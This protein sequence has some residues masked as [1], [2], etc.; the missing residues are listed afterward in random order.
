MY[1]INKGHN[2]P[3]IRRCKTL[4]GYSTFIA[5][6]REYEKKVKAREEAMK[7]A[8]SDCIKNNILKDFFEAH[9]SEVINM[10][11][12]EWNWD[13]ALAVR[14]EEGIEKG[15]EKGREE[16]QNMVLELVEKGCTPEQIRAELTALK[17]TDAG[18]A[19]GRS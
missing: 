16:V 1:N 11:Y 9:A 15:I 12:T 8:V 19:V 17:T 3:V 6:V 14:E 18:T 5:K 13:D 7:M 10:L 2:E 4:E